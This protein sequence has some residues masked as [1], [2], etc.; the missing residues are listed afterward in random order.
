MLVELESIEIDEIEIFVNFEKNVVYVFGFYFENVLV[1]FCNFVENESGI[2]SEISM[3]DNFDLDFM[4]SESS[5]NVDENDSDS[6]REDEGICGDDINKFVCDVILCV[7]E[8]K[9]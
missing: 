6:E 9:D 4:F 5:L 7:V 1:E 2:N 8:M 3:G